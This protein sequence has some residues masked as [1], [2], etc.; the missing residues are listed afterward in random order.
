MGARGQAQAARRRCGMRRHQSKVLG[1]PGMVRAG[2]GLQNSAQ[3]KGGTHGHPRDG[4][5]QLR[6]IGSV[7]R[8]G[9]VRE[10]GPRGLMLERGQQ[11]VLPHELFSAP[12][13]MLSTA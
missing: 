12:V 8:L 6:S 13:A 10:I 5:V 1:H 9:R 4:L 7:L 2:G 3:R 11:D